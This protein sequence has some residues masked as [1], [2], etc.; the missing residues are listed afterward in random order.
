[1]PSLS[2][3]RRDYR[4]VGS[5]WNCPETS[6]DRANDFYAKRR[7]ARV[8]TKEMIGGTE[9]NASAKTRTTVPKQTKVTLWHKA[10]TELVNARLPGRE[11]LE[12]WSGKVA[13]QDRSDYGVWYGEEEVV[14]LNV[15]VVEAKRETGV[16]TE[17]ALGYMGCI[18]TPRGVRHCHGL[19]KEPTT[20]ES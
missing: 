5:I 16:G 9:R 11:G 1:M 6:D 15:V 10:D 17:Q 18:S 3:L 7:F 13:S 2:A 19:R 14:S 4:L 12:V 8:S 20:S